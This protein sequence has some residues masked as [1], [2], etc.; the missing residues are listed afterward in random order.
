MI[1]AYVSVYLNEK[2]GDGSIIPGW[3][4]HGLANVISYSVVGFLI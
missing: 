3:I 4:S 2:M 1:G